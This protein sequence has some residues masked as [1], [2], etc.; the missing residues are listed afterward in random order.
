MMSKTIRPR[1]WRDQPRSQPR[2]DQEEGNTSL[3]TVLFNNP[4]LCVYSSSDEN[5]SSTPNENTWKS[6]LNTNGLCVNVAESAST[7]HLS[8]SIFVQN[9]F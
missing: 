8:D 2:V 7:R 4:C 9:A 6:L 1:A 3:P 5:I